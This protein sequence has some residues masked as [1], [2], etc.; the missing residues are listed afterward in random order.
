MRPRLGVS[1]LGVSRAGNS[2]LGVG[3][4][5]HPMLTKPLHYLDAIVLSGI[6]TDVDG[7]NNWKDQKK[8][9]SPTQTVGAQK[10]A[11][12]ARSIDFD[13]VDDNL[14]YG[15]IPVGHPLQLTGITPTILVAFEPTDAA[16]RDANARI[17]DKSTGNDGAGGWAF[18]QS[19]ADPSQ[20]AFETGGAAYSLYAAASVP[21]DV[22]S[23]V[24]VIVN[25][26]ASKSI[27]DGNINRT[28]NIVNA[29]PDTESGMKIAVAA[30]VGAVRM[31]GKIKSIYIN[32]NIMNP[33]I[34]KNL[35]KY[36]VKTYRN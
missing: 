5:F 19:N 27:L 25:G 6:I 2:R 21:D 8:L 24:G 13:G 22:L 33:V 15:T 29:I 31:K 32:T 1:R 36:A 18:R 16:G 10:A 4:G 14:T 9:L 26:A 28:I 3:R 35:W 20:I 7:V 34:I 12:D 30:F 23:M 17:I 11:Q